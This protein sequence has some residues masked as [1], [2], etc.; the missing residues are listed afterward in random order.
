MDRERHQHH[1]HTTVQPLKDQ[2]VVPEKHDAEVAA[3]QYQEVNKDSGRKVDVETKHDAEAA[4]YKDKTEK[5]ATKETKTQKGTV[6][7]EN[8]HHHLHETI[9]P[10]IEKGTSTI[11]CCRGILLTNTAETIVPE[12]THKKIPV[13]EVVREKT[14]DHGVTKKE[15]ISVD[16]FAHK[17]DGESKFKVKHD[18][19]HNVSNATAV[20]PKDA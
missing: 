12:V 10:V 8:V 16:E 4:A 6:V 18:G 1:Y 19:D 20:A 3:T 2:E 14:E 15:A 13:K 17:L 5:A 7:N 11:R 9:Q